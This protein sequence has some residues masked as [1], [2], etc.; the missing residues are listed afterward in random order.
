MIKDENFN[1]LIIL[2]A[3]LET[4]VFRS[5]IKQ[6]DMPKGL[7]QVHG[8]T[9]LKLKYRKQM[10]MTA[11]SQALNLEK[12]SIT[13]IADKLVKYDLIES[14]RCPE[15]RRVYNLTLT[16]KGKIF[17]DEFDAQH[18]MFLRNKFENY[19]DEELEKMFD[20]LEYITDMFEE[21]I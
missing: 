15:D 16:E 1:R 2:R 14:N 21:L 18:K 8:I 11:L 7:K 20:A 10:S 4:I 17:A 13:S 5:F 12:A 19:S 3:Q 9:M 6:Y